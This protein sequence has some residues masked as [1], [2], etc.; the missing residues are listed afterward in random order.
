MANTVEYDIQDSLG[1]LLDVGSQFYR[2]VLNRKL[3]PRGITVE[4]WKILIVLWDQEKLTQQELANRTC[5]NKVS[6]VKL[7][8]GLERREMVVRK[9]DPADRRLKRIV[10]TEKGR[11]LQTELIALAKLNLKQAARNI[12]PTDMVVCKDVLRQVIRNMQELVDEN[13]G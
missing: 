4:Q 9:L 3:M 2:F 7:I 8:D 5:K 10:L 13:P 11:A 12:D 1:M 6:V